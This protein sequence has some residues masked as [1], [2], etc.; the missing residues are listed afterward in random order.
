M[1]TKK[2]AITDRLTAGGKVYDVFRALRKTAMHGVDFSKATWTDPPGTSPHDW[3][4]YVP[5]IARQ[6]WGALT[7]MEKELIFIMAEEQAKNEE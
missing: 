5:D 1:A 2:T 6:C 7:D 4:K 3:R